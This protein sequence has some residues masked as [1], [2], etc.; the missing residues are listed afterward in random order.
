MAG[1]LFGD[2]CSDNLWLMDPAGDG[3]REPTSI[4]ARIGRTLSSIG[5]GEDGTVYATSLDEGELLRISGRRLT[6]GVRGR[7]AMRNV[8]V[9]V[10]AISVVP[11]ST[12]VAGIGREHHPGGLAAAA[13]PAAR[14]PRRCPRRPR[15]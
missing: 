6:E 7:Q 5:E 11:A 4:V 13:T 14:R 9:T 1:Y 3:R 8:T 12:G 2:D 10:T 15:S